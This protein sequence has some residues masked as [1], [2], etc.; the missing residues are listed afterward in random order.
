MIT[1][2]QI[3]QLRAQGLALILS[4]GNYPEDIAFSVI[5]GQ[6][7]MSLIPIQGDFAPSERYKIRKQILS[8]ILKENI[9]ANYH[10][11]ER[12]FFCSYEPLFEVDYCFEI[13]PSNGKVD[14]YISSNGVIVRRY[15]SFDISY[16]E[17]NDLANI[18]SESLVSKDKSD[19]LWNKLKNKINKLC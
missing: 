8:K 16:D 5:N 19:S 15:C 6:V 10:I 18:S 4:G 1:I 13:T 11:A 12:I 9:I 17:R 3:I 7:G 2:E 14:L